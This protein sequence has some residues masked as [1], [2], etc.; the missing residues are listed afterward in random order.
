MKRLIILFVC[1]SFVI[2][3]FAGGPQYFEHVKSL[4]AQ[5]RYNEAI[6]GFT[7]CIN[8]YSDELKGE[9]LNGWIKKCHESI[10]R[11]Q[12]EKDRRVREQILYAE[13]KA[14]HE[15]HQRQIEELNL[16]FISTNARTLNGN[17]PSMQ[18]AIK[19]NLKSFEFAKTVDDAKWGVYVTANAREYNNPNGLYISYVDAIVQVINMVNGIIVFEQEY[20]QK[21]G[22]AKDYSE[23]VKV[24]YNKIIKQISYDIIESVNNET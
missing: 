5:E 3:S 20:S 12:E 16:I 8:L 17:Y 11:Q 24:A 2:K 23:A 22:H 6:Q 4:Y 7:I 18:N 21:G 1:L 15:R 14:E 19:G 10:R 9:D 13:R